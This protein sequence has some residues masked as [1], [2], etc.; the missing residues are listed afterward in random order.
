MRQI[1]FRAKALGTISQLDEAGLH[2]ENGWVTGNLLYNEYIINGVIDSNDEYIAI[3][4]WC[5]IDK[6]TVGHFAISLWSEIN[7]FEIIG[8]IYENPELL[9]VA[10]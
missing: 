7:E 3:E 2:H 5:Q 9:G 10:E 6:N 4:N 8:N 1:E